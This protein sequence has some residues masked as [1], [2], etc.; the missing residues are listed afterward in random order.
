[1][2]RLYQAALFILLLPLHFA[3]FAQTAQIRGTVIDESGEP[4]VGATV[5]IPSIKA[6]A[7]TND[8][9]IFSINRLPSGTYQVKAFYFGFDTLTQEVKVQEG[10]LVTTKFVLQEK[11][12]FTNEVN[13]YG[14]QTGKIDTREVTTG[15][16]EISPREIK[17]LPSVGGADL[18]QYIQVLPG[19]VF[20]GDQGGQVYIR[21]GTP[22]Q[23]MV[24]LDGMVIYSPFHSIGL[25]SVF[26]PDY[27]RNVTVYS[28]GMPANYGGRISS[29][30]DV[31]TRTPDFR[32]FHATVN[33]NPFT[34]SAL[35]EAPI[36]KSKKEGGGASFMLSARNNYINRTSQTLY[37]YINDTTGL[38][39]S[40]LD[41]YGKLTL[42]DGINNANF[43]GFTHQDNVEYGFPADI[44]WNSSG[45]GAN[46]QVLPAGAAAI[47][48]GSFAVSRYSTS[49]TSQSETFPRE[50]AINGFNGGLNVAYIINSIDEF[51]AGIQFLGFGT[52]FTFTNS[53]GLVTNQED[54]NTEAAIYLKYKKVFLTGLE[55]RNG[56]RKELAV[57]EPGVHL[58]YYNNQPR[59][60][61]E[62][63]IRAKLNLPRASFSL[64]GGLFSQNLLAAVSDRDV[65]NLF[66]GFLSSPLSLGNQIN[67]NTLQTAWHALGGAEFEII[68]GV[69]TNIEAWY[70]GFTQLVSV[71]RDKVLPTDPNFIT[72]TGDAYGFDFLVKYTT[73]KVFLYANY[74]WAKVLRDDGRRLYP[75]VFD[76]RHT[77]NLLGSYSFGKRVQVGSG[78]NNRKVKFVE[79][80]WEVSARWTLGSGFPFTQTQGYFEKLDFIDNGVQS[81]IGTQ[82]GN[83]TLVLADELNGG[84]LPYYHRLDL[85]AKWRT[86]IASSALLEL[87][88]SL[89]NTYNRENIFYFD[90]VRFA[91][92]NQ[93]PILPSIGA[94]LK[95]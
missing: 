76:R 64:S 50:S 52:D 83:L 79:P 25:F 66:Q 36:T 95:Y 67:N 17:I 24:L 40:F 32:K 39:F 55:D 93:L 75:P 6:G 38:P 10:Q 2:P 9:G 30:I 94:T 19:V 63:R 34:S 90:R 51:A 1:M 58:H 41:I 15:I 86:A 4:L 31:K 7:F 13:I 62:P 89:I 77:V 59:P 53:F 47:I 12:V 28:A 44:G 85:G 37:P 57:I 23:N 72:E 74:G 49:L 22:V 21:G 45:G 11:Q 70:K 82:N 26:D 14:Q 73:S 18:A 81:P 46:F 33:A 65:V 92:V 84:R 35:I 68:P 42:S 43:F 61:I 69:T 8:L 48:S 3:V 60:Q 20:T 91:A 29:V 78:P 71:N 27:I 87:N 80:Q 5:F 54:D 88:A 56:Q 16:T